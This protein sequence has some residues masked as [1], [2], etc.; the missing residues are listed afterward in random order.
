MPRERIR[1]DT[2]MLPLIATYPSIQLVVVVKVPICS[3]FCIAVSFLVLNFGTVHG[4]GI[5][6]RVV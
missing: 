6:T 2:Y 4:L 5:E 3:I 1:G